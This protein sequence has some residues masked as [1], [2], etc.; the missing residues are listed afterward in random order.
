V[1]TDLARNTLYLTVA[2]VGQKLIA[3][4][5]FLFLARVMEPEL[6][7]LYFLAISIAMIFSVLADFGITPVTIREIAAHPEQTHTLFRR[8]LAVKIPLLLI[9]YLLTILCVPVLGYSRELLPLVALSGLSLVLDSIH[10][11]FYGVLRGHQQLQFEAIGMFCGQVIVVMIGGAALFFYPSIPLLLTALV[12]GSAFNVFVSATTVVKR[13]G[14]QML[15]PDAERTF[16]MRLIHMAFPF[17]LSAIFVKVYSYIDTVFISKFLTTSAVGLY[18]VAYKLTYAFQFIP[19]SFTAALYPNFSAMLQREPAAAA[20]LLRRALWYM[21]I[22]STPITLGLWLIAEP[23]VLLAGA[24]YAPSAPV[25]AVLVFVLIPIF[26]DF[27]IGSLLNAAGR[28]ATKTAIMGATMVVNVLFNILLIPRIGVLGAAY[29]ALASFLF[30]FLAGLWAVR[31]LVPSFSFTAFLRDL[32]WILLSGG[33]MAAIG[34]LAL[35]AIGW[36][37]VIPLCALVY[38]LALVATRSF[39]KADW[40]KVRSLTRV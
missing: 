2:S 34:R 31:G 6:T 9:G 14:W 17:A 1:S 37:A 19:L 22:V 4:V 13:F 27:P 12:S 11:L 35:P 10:L 7:G 39:T 20:S 40:V 38:G 25:L 21:L 32:S 15:V 29:A 26:L 23:L 24:S 8:A 5:Y 16:S 28:Q 18:S 3:F 36:I 30:M 33:V